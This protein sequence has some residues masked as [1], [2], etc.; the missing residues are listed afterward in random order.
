MRQELCVFSPYSTVP[1]PYWGHDRVHGELSVGVPSS[2]RC[3]QSIPRQ[4]IK[5]DGLGSVEKQLSLEKP[6][7]R[8]SNLVWTNLPAAVMRRRV[9]EDTMQIKSEIAQ[10]LLLEL[11]FNLE[12]MHLLNHFSD[13][14]RQ[15]GNLLNVSSELREKAMMEPK[16]VY[17][18]W[19]HHEDTYQMLRMT[20]RKE[21]FLYRE[22]NANAPKQH[23]NDNMP[24]TNAPMKQMMKNPQPEIKTLDDFAEWCAMPKGELPNHIAWCFKI[25]ASVIVYIT[26]HQYFSRLNNGKY[27]RYNAVAIPVASFQCDEHAVHMVGCTAS[28]RWRKHKPP[29]YDALLLWMGTSPNGHFESTAGRIPTRLQCLLVV[30]DAKS[31]VKV[32]LAL[33]QTFAAGPKRVTAGMVI[34]KERHQ[35]Q[36]Q[37]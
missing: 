28:T 24:L 3:L 8:E 29:R 4:E 32:L 36:M 22:V 33:A 31:S 16:Q 25:F 37:S 2:E 26:H 30:K 14:I 34:V 18:E 20:A 27:I 7:E 10:H 15:L 6:K 35:P 12:K 9:D 23:C 19:N 5:H 21:V 17:R 13:H 1:V 11:D